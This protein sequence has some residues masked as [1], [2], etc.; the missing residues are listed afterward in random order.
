MTLPNVSLCHM[1]DEKLDDIEVVG[2]E[3]D[4]VSRLEVVC[5]WSLL[6]IMSQ[7]GLFILYSTFIAPL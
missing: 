5:W 1:I 4:L 3:V 6:D 7:L 2:T